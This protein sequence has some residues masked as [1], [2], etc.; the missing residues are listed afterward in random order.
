MLAGKVGDSRGWGIRGVGDSRE[1]GS[2]G[3]VG[4]E[5]A[6]DLSLKK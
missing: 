5:T 3:G 2:R 1:W 6:N 4:I